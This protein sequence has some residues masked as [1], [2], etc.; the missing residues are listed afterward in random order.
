MVQMNAKWIIPPA[1]CT[2]LLAGCTAI[3]G[4]QF[5]APRTGVSLPTQAKAKLNSQSQIAALKS[6]RRWTAGLPRKM[7]PVFQDSLNYSDTKEMDMLKMKKEWFVI[8]AAGLCL[9]AAGCSQWTPA[10][11]HRE[12]HTV[13][14]ITQNRP[15]TGPTAHNPAVV[16]LR[17]AIQAAAQAAGPMGS[18]VL[19][20]VAAIASLIA[21]ATTTAAAR[22]KSQVNRHKQAVSELAR[23]IPP[24]T[25]LHPAT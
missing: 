1:A 13:E 6:I 20:I 22:A 25:I 8:P 18:T 3:H 17:P 16:I 23:V 2:M 15:P 21:G 9:L 4:V 19:G 7:S 10:L 12:S 5:T 11:I 14:A 24:G